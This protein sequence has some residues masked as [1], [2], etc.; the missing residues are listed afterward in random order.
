MF[1]VLAK[2]PVIFLHWYHHFTVLLYCWHAYA[3]RSS[4]GLYF[5]AMNYGVHALMY[6]YFALTA[7]GYKP[8]WSGV[9]T[10]LQISQMFVG[11][12]VCAAVYYFRDMQGL[13][14]HVAQDNFIAAVAMYISYA[15][16]FCAFA[17]ER[18]CRPAK[19]GE[20]K[21]VAAKGAKAA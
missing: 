21:K 14:C 16:L 11:V 4:T 6:Y 2:K 3:T 10:T 18:Y 13:S 17:V 20:G 1:L 7:M 5:T 8:W 19:K 12:A 15:V 9:V